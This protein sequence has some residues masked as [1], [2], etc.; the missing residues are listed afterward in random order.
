MKSRTPMALPMLAAA[1]FTLTAQAQ[2][3]TPELNTPWFAEVG[4]T[5]LSYKEQFAGDEYTIRPGVLTLAGGYRVHPNLSLE[6]LV[7][8]SI[9]SSNVKMNG[10]DT[11]VTAK[12]PYFGLFV[13]P[14]VQVSEG[15]DV[16]GR[17]GY[18][19]SRLDMKGPLGSTSGSEGSFAWGLGLNV[20]VSTQSY[21]QATWTQT[22]KKDGIRIAGFGLAY[23]MKF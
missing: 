7:G 1:L 13:R 6:G 8:L 2:S 16:F 17:L 22:Y 11:G 10:S 19:R 14:T 18:V 5:A 4:Y 3:Q 15:V 21:V 20:D 12:L 9:K 23:G